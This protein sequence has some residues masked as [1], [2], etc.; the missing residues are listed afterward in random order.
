MIAATTAGACTLASVSTCEAPAPVE[1]L[2]VA[3]D[4]CGI[5]ATSDGI[6][7]ARH[8]RRDALALEMA[9]SDPYL[10]RLGDKFGFDQLS[11]EARDGELESSA[12]VVGRYLNPD[13][14]VGYSQGLFSPEGT[15][16]LRLRLSD[17]LEL[18]SRSGAEQS[19]DV[20]YRLERE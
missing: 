13:L 2:V 12:L 17:Q 3:V 14:Y 8:P 9:R 19:A 18:E 11:L 20:F 6:G 7:L 10:Q 15:V 1:S 16:L 4:G 5:V